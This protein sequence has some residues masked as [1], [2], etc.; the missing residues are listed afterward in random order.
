MT[1]I[2]SISM[3]LLALPLCLAVAGCDKKDDKKDDKTA[4]KA[5]AKG[6][7]TAD[8]KADAKPEPEPEPEKPAIEMVEHDLG[9]AD[10]EWEGWVAQGPKGAKVMADG[11]KGARIA[12]DGR[13][14]FDLAFAPKTTDLASL[15]G[16]VEKGAEAS[17]GKLT[18]TFTSDTP[19]LL[20]WIADGYGAKRYNFVMNMTAGDR[21]VTCKNNYMMGIASE[22]DLAAHKAACETL[23]KKD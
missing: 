15:K 6:D 20:E 19:E 12:A 1:K 11:V 23:A 3:T 22:D 5:D 17:D 4:Q 18:L 14:G 9:S 21:E 7:A 10:P 13:D 16:N 8:E 2:A